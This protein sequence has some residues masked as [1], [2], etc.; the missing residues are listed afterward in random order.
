MLVV[1]VVL[2][3]QQRENLSKVDAAL[4]EQLPQRVSL[5]VDSVTAIAT[6]ANG[7]R[8]L[9]IPLGDASVNP[10]EGALEKP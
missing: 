8:R 6:G 2:R 10:G 9:V 4:R 3:D 1:R 7:K 5:R